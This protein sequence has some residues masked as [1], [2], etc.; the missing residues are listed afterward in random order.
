MLLMHT[1]R[2]CIWYRDPFDE[3]LTCQVWYF[4]NTRIIIKVTYYIGKGDLHNYMQF[5]LTLNECVNYTTAYKFYTIFRDNCFLSVVTTL[6]I[7]NCCQR[8]HPL[9]RYLDFE[10]NNIKVYYDNNFG[11]KYCSNSEFQF[12][13]IC[14][15]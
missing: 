7:S 10:L 1:D 2:N 12:H 8:I 11:K 15:V 13:L 4:M 9:L 5:V 3:S 14:I 6:L